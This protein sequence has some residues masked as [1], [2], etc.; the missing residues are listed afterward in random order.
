MRTR[1]C[2]ACALD[3]TFALYTL[4]GEPTNFDWRDLGAVTAVKNQAECGS[5]WSFST[6]GDVEGTK[7]LGSGGTI[8]HSLSE[9]QLVA[10]NTMN[11]GC[12]GGYP[13]AAMQYA[14]HF[15]GL[16]H[17]E[18]YEYKAINEGSSGTPSCDTATLNSALERDDYE[19]KMPLA[20]VKN[21]P[22][23]VSFNANGMEFYV[24]GIV[25][26]TTGRCKSGAIDHEVPCDPDSLDHAVLI[27]GYGDDDINYWVI[28]N[29]WGS[30]WGEAGYYRLV[31]GTN[32]CGVANMVV[33]SVYKAP[34]P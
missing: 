10:C 22:L 12:D 15:G 9:Q 31:R 16:V 19:K 24:E 29:S 20:L 18:D 30:E 32:A 13:F 3:K 25:G 6:C 1:D 4:G 8:L 26:C 7:F 23:S 2:A 14:A 33:H 28:K 5:C 34:G 17:L 27:V 11:M 21:G